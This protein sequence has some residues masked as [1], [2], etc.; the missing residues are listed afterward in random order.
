VGLAILVVVVAAQAVILESVVLEEPRGLVMLVLEVLEVVEA[1][2]MI[3]A[4]VAA[5]EA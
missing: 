2:E 3:L 5:V 1:V 4:A